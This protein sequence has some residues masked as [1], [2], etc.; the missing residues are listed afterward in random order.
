[1]E[2]ITYQ[3]VTSYLLSIPKFTVKHTMEDTCAFY[4]YMGSPCA[5][6]KIIHVAGTNGKGSTCTYLRSMLERCGHHTALFVSPH[7]V[8][9]RERFLF[10]GVPVLEETFCKS[11]MAVAKLLLV[12]HGKKEPV[13]LET[14][15]ELP[16][17]P[18][19]FEML[20][21][22]FLQCRKTSDADY[23]ILETGLGG[24]LDAT[25]CMPKKA[26]CV[27]TRIA[28]DHTEY[29]GETVG[30]IAREKAGIFRDSTPIVSLRSD[31][32]SAEEIEV[33]ARKCK[34][35]LQFVDSRDFK[36]E[37][38]A[39]KS[40]AFSFHSVYYNSISLSLSTTAC[41]QAENAALA[42]RAM[43]T[44][45]VH[46]TVDELREGLAAAHWEGRMEEVLPEVF[47]DGAHNEDG[48]RA[49]LATVEQT[50]PDR[51]NV[52]VLA[53][54]ADKRYERMAEFIA[55][56]GLFLRV[57]VTS[58][59]G[60]RALAPK[61]LVGALVSYGQKNCMVQ[62]QPEQAFSRCLSEREADER[63]FAAG[64]LYLIGRIKAY[65]GRN[66]DD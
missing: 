8:T 26:L 48:I 15:R 11:F 37:R 6:A 57:Y 23:V 46:P 14:L 13:S 53:I 56:S 20:F 21:F 2:E 60:E 39:N 49:L 10:D 54:V 7:L 34:A 25:N 65:L 61:A 63:V 9:M 3:E 62:E 47:L 50:G 24:R 22:M 45:L 27:I 58:A 16:Y 30:Q 41:Y 38:I 19:F 17:H 28:L 5:D 18:S 1:M 12:Y 51:K 33:R 35:P 31:K 55:R 42:L 4:Q 29:L 66:S 44:L 36:I 43:E 40:I 64:S 59:G 32:E 52:L